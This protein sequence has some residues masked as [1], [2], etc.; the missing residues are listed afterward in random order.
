MTCTLEVPEHSGHVTISW[1]P[2]KPD[3]VERARREFDQLKAAG[4]AFYSDEGATKPKLRLGK[5]GRLEGRLVQP[6]PEVVK[7][8]NPRRGRTVAMRPMRGG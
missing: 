1:D 7:D 3:E 5:S 6:T 4:F 8:F 2:D